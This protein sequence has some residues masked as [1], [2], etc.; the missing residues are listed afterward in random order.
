MPSRTGEPQ[1]VGGADR[2]P[3][4]HIRLSDEIHAGWR[5]HFLRAAH[6]SGLFQDIRVGV[7]AIIFGI[8]SSVLSLAC[9][10]IDAWI[11]EANRATTPSATA[12]PAPAQCSVPVATIMVVDDQVEVGR[13]AR[14]IL[15]PAGY[16]VILTSDPFEALRL[17]RNSSL[18]IDLLLTDIVMPVMDGRE[19]ARRILVIRPDIK[20][21]LMSAYDVSGVAATSWPFIPKP[22]GVEGLKHKIADVLK[23]RS[24]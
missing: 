21:V 7:D 5:R 23:E 11:D 20:I 2:L 3:T 8:E 15:E 14:D 18:T 9:E 6:A 19:L 16:S 24:S 1:R 12:L 22:F 4:W 13:V 17:A 10:K